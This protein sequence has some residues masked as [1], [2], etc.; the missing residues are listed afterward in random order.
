MKKITAIP[1]SAGIAIGPVFIYQPAKFEIPHCQV[2]DTGEELERL[3]TA[4]KKSIQA[5]DK[6]VQRAK[7]KL[8]SNEAAIFEAHKEMLDD[9]ELLQAAQDKIKD[10]CQNAEAAFDEAAEGYAKML[11]GMEDEYFRARAA[12]IRDVKKRVI[13]NLLGIEPGAAFAGLKKPSIIAAHDLTP[14]DTIALDKSLVL[15]F[16]TAYGGPTSHTAILA[17]GLGL[18]AVVGAGAEILALEAGKEAILDGHHGEVILEA[19]AGLIAQYRQQQER[20]SHS[21]E[22]ALKKAHQPAVTKDGHKVEVAANIGSVKEAANAV[23]FGAEG[24]GLLRTEFVYLHQDWLPSE[25]EQY[26]VYKQILDEFGNYPVILRTLDIG[27][28]KEVPYLNIAQEM[29]SF[30]G[31]RAVRLCLN[32]PDLF[33]PQL[34]AALRAAQ[35]HAMR[36]MFPMIAT[37]QEVVKARKV[38]DEC[39]QELLA[40]GHALPDPVSTGIMVEIPSAVLLADHLSKVVD[41]FSIGTNDLTQY[42]MAADRT[43]PTVGYLSSAFSPAVLRLIADLITV[44][45]RNGKWVGMCGELAGEALAVPILLGLG[46]DE[47]SMNA[48]AIPGIKEIIRSM[49]YKECQ[50][51]A[52]EALKL[53]EADEVQDY[54][55]KAVPGIK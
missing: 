12:D 47:F 46:L 19:D 28:D 50:Q 51:I 55:R 53:S 49:S 25:E 9:P 8:G 3:K 1:A 52:Q 43:N 45:H 18:P 15:G 34:R 39:R 27:G 48:P 14:S 37:V 6:D 17:R 42:T 2:Q 24:V 16:V 13:Q 4:L 44:A 36:I 35:G 29:N 32:R 23:A 40:E 10:Q 31:V 5:L 20:E 38:M 21:M 41:F 7:E 26:Q 11:D 22:E 30:L 33:K 54:I